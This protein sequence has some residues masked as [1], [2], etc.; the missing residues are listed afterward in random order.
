MCGEKNLLCCIVPENVQCV[1]V[2]TVCTFSGTIIV[3]MH[4]SVCSCGKGLSEN[5]I[6]AK[7]R[8]SI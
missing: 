1:P 8:N 6:Q 3:T 4:S 5:A 7:G 2:V